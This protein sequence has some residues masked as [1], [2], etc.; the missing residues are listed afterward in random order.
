MGSIMK[1]VK[2][3]FERSAPPRLRPIAEENIS[4]LR[5]RAEYSKSM[6]EDRTFQEI[7]QAM[8]EQIVQEI[9]NSGPLDQKQ[10][11]VLYL[12]L[13]LITEIQET[14]MTF[15]NEFETYAL[16]QEAQTRQEEAING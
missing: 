15:I 1:S 7:F 13:K 8:N 2:S 12:K 11:D 9:A 6:I 4:T 14:L 5:K 3:F 10:R 16:I